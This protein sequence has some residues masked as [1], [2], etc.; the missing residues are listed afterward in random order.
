MAYNVSSKTLIRTQ[1]NSVRWCSL[2][3]TTFHSEP[4]MRCDADIPQLRR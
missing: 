3:T 1:L 4:N 2:A